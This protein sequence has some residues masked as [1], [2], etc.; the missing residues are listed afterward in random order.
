ACA[1][2]VKSVNLAPLTADLATL[3]RLASSGG[4]TMEQRAVFRA[5]I[6]RHGLF[7]RNAALGRQEGQLYDVLLPLAFGKP[8]SYQAYCQVEDCLGT[9]SITP[10]RRLLQA[11]E[12][13]GTGDARVTAIVIG[14]LRQGEPLYALLEPVQLIDLLAGTWERPRHFRMVCDVTLDYLTNASDRYDQRTVRRALRRHG[15]LAQ[16]LRVFGSTDQYQVHALYR[17]LVATFPGELDRAAVIHVL[18]TRPPDLATPALLAAVLL[19]TASQES[20]WLT[21]TAY[22]RASLTGL[23]LRANTWGQVESRLSNLDGA[24]GDFAKARPNQASVND[25]VPPPPDP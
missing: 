22:A 5:G 8:L 3:E 13:L 14:R 17:L 15:Y 9:P 10:H 19:R 24:I 2:H 12:R 18:S 1:E 21:A 16:T 4:L 25:H 23:S 20:A 7:K 11:I 6:A